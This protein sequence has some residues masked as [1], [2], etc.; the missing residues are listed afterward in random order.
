MDGP[1]ML[2]EYYL[3]L[4]KLATNGVPKCHACSAN[5]WWGPQNM[6][7]GDPQNEANVLHTFNDGLKQ[8]RQFLSPNTKSD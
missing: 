1:T 3:W 6:H 5:F 8:N 2:V 4:W 7:G